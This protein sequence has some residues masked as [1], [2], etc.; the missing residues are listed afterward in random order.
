MDVNCS[1][2]QERL[3][4]NELFGHERG[5]F[6]DAHETKKG[7][8]ELCDQGTLFLDEVGDM[9]LATQAKLL[10]FIDQQKLQAGG[11]G[12]GHRGRHPDHRRHQQAPR[13]G[14]GRMAGFARTSTTA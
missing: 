6:T 2:F 14:G 11:R 13:R 4:E 10:R 1:S 5:A 3:L 12:A 7:L 9:P 8:V